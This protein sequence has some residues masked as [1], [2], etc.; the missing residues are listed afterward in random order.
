M[1]TTDCPCG[2][3]ERIQE[4]CDKWIA[5]KKGAPTAE[6]L[7]HTFSDAT[8]EAMPELVRT[9]KARGYR[10]VTVSELLPA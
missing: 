8:L 1:K 10:C 7:M 5:G 2:S 9:I 3:G 4:C 6:A